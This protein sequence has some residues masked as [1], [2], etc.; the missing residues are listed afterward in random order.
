MFSSLSLA[1]ER[2]KKKKESNS[3]VIDLGF[4]KMRNDYSVQV[5]QLNS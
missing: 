3:Q 4:T 5:G 1:Y 2:K